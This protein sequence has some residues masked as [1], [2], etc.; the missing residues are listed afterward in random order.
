MYFAAKGKTHPEKHCIGTATASRVSG[1]YTPASEP[2][3]CDLPRGGNID[4][5]LFQDPVN[6]KYYLIYKTDGN[7][8]GNGGACGNTNVKVAPTPL[9]LQEL[10]PS[11]L[12]TK[13]GD[14]VF[15]VSNLNPVG[16]FKFDGPNTERP[17]IAFKNDTYYLLYNA[18]CYADL[19]YRIDFVSCVVGVDTK[20]GMDGCDW[21]DLKA[22][23]QKTSERTLLKTG[24]SVSGVNLYAPGSMDTST[25][26]SKMVF[27]GDTNV[28][29]F[30]QNPRATEDKVKRVRAMYA[31]AIDYDHNSGDLVVVKLL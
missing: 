9:Y 28:A 26:S 16:S 23:Q 2:L 19:R 13:I 15:L 22:K 3:I 17:S 6:K 30:H 24:D 4:P 27:H 31:A 18:Q 5:N 7:A 10:S 29:W 1:P 11:D 14:P 8:I 12:T 25:D 21:T 20:G